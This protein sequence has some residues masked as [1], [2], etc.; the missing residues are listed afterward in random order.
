M[1]IE[2]NPRI[3]L[4]D[5]VFFIASKKEIIY[6]EAERLL[7]SRVFEGCYICDDEDDDCFKEV[8][9]YLK[10]NSIDAVEVYQD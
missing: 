3:D 2:Y 10:E 7:P 6:T 4:V 9:Q 8:V 5:L 1:N